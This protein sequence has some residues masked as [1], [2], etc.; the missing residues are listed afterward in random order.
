MD[1]QFQT[2]FK[3]DDSKDYEP[4][5]V[6]YDQLSEAV[7]V[8]E[9]NKLLR[10]FLDEVRG[11]ASDIRDVDFF[12]K[13]RKELLDITERALAIESAKLL[14]VTVSNGYTKILEG[15]NYEHRGDQ[16][17]KEITLMKVLLQN[18]CRVLYQS[19]MHQHIKIEGITTSVVQLKWDIK[20][21]S[22]QMNPYI[23]RLIKFLGD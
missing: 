10:I 21:T 14:V 20:E 3:F 7:V 6:Q 15:L 11:D 2:I 16:I 23:D 9:R 4:Y 12:S 1:E 19:Y 8:R 18:F 22:T 17:N 13:E 5:M